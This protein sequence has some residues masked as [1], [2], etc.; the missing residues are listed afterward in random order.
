MDG[1]SSKL[2]IPGERSIY[3]TEKLVRRLLQ[4]GPE[5]DSITRAARMLRKM[6]DIAVLAVATV[7]DLDSS[8][9]GH[10]SSARRRMLMK[11]HIIEALKRKDNHSIY[12]AAV[13]ADSLR[14]SSDQIAELTEKANKEAKP[15]REKPRA[16]RKGNIAAIT[17]SSI[18]T[19]LL[20][21]AG[22]SGYLGEVLPGKAH[23]KKAEYPITMR[24]ITKYN[25]EENGLALRAAEEYKA[26]LEKF[27]DAERSHTTNAE[28]T[29][30]PLAASTSKALAKALDSAEALEAHSHHGPVI[31]AKGLAIALYYYKKIDSL[32]RQGGFNK[33]ADKAEV[34][35]GR[36]RNLIKLLRYN[37]LSIPPSEAI[38]KKQRAKAGSAERETKARVRV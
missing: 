18:A 3:E 20:L 28:R 5:R 24:Y 14:L 27:K 34:D 6:L 23:N 9:P 1:D 10:L 33:L 37:S 25:T 30:F 13:M 19:A 21:A 32:S 36:D 29:A 11:S 16:L 2:C 15:K 35:I 26:A 8:T 22:A 17:G 31:D 4:S 12:E 7:A 38:A